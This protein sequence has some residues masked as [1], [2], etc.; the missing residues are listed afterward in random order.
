MAKRKLI[1]LGGGDLCRELLWTAQLIPADQRDWEPF[2]VLDDNVEG[3]RTHMLRREITLPV[4]GS[5]SDYKPMSDEVFIPAIGKPINKLNATELLE[6]R[7]ATFI[8]L[9]HPSA[10]ISLDARLGRGIFIF[11][12][13]IVSVGACLHDFVTL[14][15]FV[16]V[17]HDARIGRGCSLNPG[18]I[19][20]G[21]V[22]LGRGVTM[23]TQA[24][25]AP[26][27][28]V[29]DFATIGIGSAVVNSIPAD[30]TVVG[31]P[32]RAMMPSRNKAASTL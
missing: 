9:I 7:G 25:I 31:V 13:S 10:Q 19:V 23:G 26:Q 6:S 15:A 18:A 5:I 11:A 22:T 2:G 27:L 32:A 4:L 1:F 28:E 3:A 24:S 12:N 29:G 17:G 16:L 8:N 14:N 30:L 21:N 20:T